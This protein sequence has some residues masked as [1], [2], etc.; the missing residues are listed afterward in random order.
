LRLPLSVDKS[1]NW[2]K[3]SSWIFRSGFGTHPVVSVMAR[4]Y[5]NKDEELHSL[6]SKAA[7]DQGANV[8]IPD[9]QRPYV[10]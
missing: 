2:A 9:L 8:L 7:N 6:L 10:S 4:I 1:S 5:D 3:T